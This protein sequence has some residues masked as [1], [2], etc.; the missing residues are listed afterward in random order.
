MTV[1]WTKPAHWQTLSLIKPL[2]TMCSRNIFLY[3]RGVKLLTLNTEHTNPLAFQRVLRVIYKINFNINHI[4]FFN[5]GLGV[6]YSSA[7][8]M[9]TLSLSLTPKLLCVSLSRSHLQWSDRFHSQ[10]VFSFLTV[11]SESVCMRTSRWPQRDVAVA[12]D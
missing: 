8:W 2:L 6:I 7:A 12:A 5:S 9:K 1:V 3:L 4:H 11:C 10:R